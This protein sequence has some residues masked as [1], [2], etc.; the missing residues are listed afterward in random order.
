MRTTL[1]LDD[2]LLRQAKSQAAARGETLTGILEG[3][4]RERLRALSQPVRSFRFE[5]VVKGGTLVPGAQIDDRD[6]LYERME[7]R[8]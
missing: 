8:A 7:G 3:A 4:L 6:A 1:D 2:R 5:P